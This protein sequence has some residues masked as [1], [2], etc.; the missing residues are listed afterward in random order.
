MTSTRALLRRIADRAETEPDA[1]L[2][3]LRLLAGEFPD[4]N[5]TAMPDPALRTVAL[6]INRTR[7]QQA[8]REFIANAW[9]A[10]RVAEHLGVHSRQA[11]AQRRA[12]GKLLGS[13]VGQSVYYPA[14]Q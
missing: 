8:Q 6:Q 12:R 2:P 9:S 7:V 4:D 3:V 10:E 5:T 13:Q 11:V 14:W 1:I